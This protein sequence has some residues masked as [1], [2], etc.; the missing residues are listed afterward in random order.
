M[1]ARY[2]CSAITAA[3][4]TFGVD[5][6]AP[7]LARAQQPTIL[8]EEGGMITLVGCLQRG[9][10]HDKYLLVDPRMGSVVSVPEATCAASG[11]E[12]AVELKDTSRHYQSMLGRYVEITGRLERI[13]SSDDPDDLRELHVRS[14]REI[15]VVPPQIAAAPPPSEP[16]Q[17][18]QPEPPAAQATPAAP[19]ERP[20]A[21]TGTAP[22]PAS[23]P[24]TASASSLIGLVGL[25]SLGGAFALRL[26]HRQRAQ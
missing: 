11:T 4:L 18:I 2:L 21:T 16:P 1:S 8:P 14:F 19:E 20:V 17:V 9:G 10:K 15:P 5:T 22:A 25:L 3:L 24:R 26:F 7:A 13:E 6:T 23:L 12:Q